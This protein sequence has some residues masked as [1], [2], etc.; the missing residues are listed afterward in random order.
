VKRLFLSI[1]LALEAVIVVV[2]LNSTFLLIG[3]MKSGTGVRITIG[4]VGIAVSISI[5]VILVLDALRVRVKLNNLDA[6]HFRD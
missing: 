5:A 1:W 4:L 6:A 3:I 2:L